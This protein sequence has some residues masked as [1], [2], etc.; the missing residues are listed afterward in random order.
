VNDFYGTLRPKG[1]VWHWGTHEVGATPQ[2]LLTRLRRRKLDI[3][4]VEELIAEKP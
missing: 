2:D 1:G 4:L 3:Q